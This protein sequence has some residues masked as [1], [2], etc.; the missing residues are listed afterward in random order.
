MKLSRPQATVLSSFTLLLLLLACQSTLEAGRQPS[1]DPPP[2]EDSDQE[3]GAEHA[4]SFEQSVTLDADRL[5]VTFAEVV[6]DNRCPKGVQCIVGGEAVVVLDVG[7]ETSESKLT[8]AIGAHADAVHSFD[9]YTIEV[10]AVDP[11]PTASRQV[12][13][14]DYVVRFVALKR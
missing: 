2:P 5:T 9:G 1:P 12:A 3:P 7:T 10:L 8:F 14:E 6:R 4:L 11:E 13:V